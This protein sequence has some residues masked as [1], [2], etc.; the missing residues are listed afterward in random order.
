MARI[1]LDPFLMAIIAAAVVASFL[2]ATGIGA[3]VL[4]VATKVAIF[5]L[6]F[7]YGARLHPEEALRGLKHWK[8]HLTI[9]AFTFVVFPLIGLAI[10][11]L[12]GWALAPA[13]IPGMVYVT[14]CPSTVQSSI[15]FTSIA[16]GNVAGA[17]VSASASNLLGVFLTPLLAIALMNTTGNAN[18]GLGSIVDLV[19]QILLP[20]ILGQLS[21]RWTADFVARHKKLKLFDQASIVMVVYAAFSQG[22]REGIWSMVGWVDIVALVVVCLVLLAFMLWFTWFT[23]RRLGF[24]RADAIAIQMCGTKKSLATGLPMATVLFAGQPIGLIMLPLMV[25][26]Q[27][28]LMACSWLAARYA[29]DPEPDAVATA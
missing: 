21:R 27:A 12:P 11:L 8:L 6:F 23:A 25:F 16:R 14:L 19:V 9:L 13:L 2:P 1:K 22:I 4:S 26:H 28:Q 17:I 7:L 10:G 18:V 29:R 20:F 15:N 5:C 24:N 3:Q